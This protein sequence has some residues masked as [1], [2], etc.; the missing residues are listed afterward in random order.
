MFAFPKPKISN[1][2]ISGGSDR[3]CLDRRWLTTQ[4]ITGV[5]AILISDTIAHVEGEQMII[6][7][8]HPVFASADHIRYHHL[9]F[10]YS[11][12]QYHSVPAIEWSP[13]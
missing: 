10:Q 7:P 11:G 3:F 13:V 5:F 12:K 6:V 4:R 8:R 2:G 9:Q 1:F